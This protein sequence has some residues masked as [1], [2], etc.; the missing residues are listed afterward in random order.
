MIEVND[1]SFTYAGSTKP[2]LKHIDLQIARGEIIGFLGPSGAGKS[3]AQK[4]LIG[5]LK[6]YQGTVTVF[7]R[8]LK[9]WR[10]DYYERIGVAFEQ[11]NHYLKLSALEN[12]AYFRSLYAGETEEPQ[13]L[14]ELVGLA[15]DGKK[16]VSQFSKGMGMRLNVAR[17][18]LNKPEL[19]FL[20]EPTSGLD[21]VNARQIKDLLQRKRQEGMTIFLTTHNM[22][23][24]DEL[25]DRVAFLIDGVIK[26]VDAP[27]KLKI[28]R[29]KRLVEVEYGLYDHPQRQLF[30]LDGLAENSAFLALL[31]AAEYLLAKM[32]SLMLLALLEGTLL[33]ILI[34]GFNFNPLPWFAGLLL[35]SGFY[36]LLGFA[37]IA[38]YRSLN[39][40]LLP[41]ALVVA[42]LVSP[43]LNHF[44]LWRSFIFYLH[45]VQP[46]LILLRWAF[47][48]VA[49]WEI[50]Y[51]L[52]G[53]LFW[54]AVAFAIAHRVFNRAI[55]QTAGG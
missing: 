9:A 16:P 28:E 6:S 10:S 53:S 7:G 44:G 29:G 34:N 50:V 20:D 35:L 4:I 41:S 3:T 54:L 43:I 25:C 27:E 48:P 17:A 37:V 49:P 40:S 11:P 26:L 8:D 47:M 30:P 1:L 12:L 14:L 15:D 13:A 23:V 22:T 31:R 38:R 21:P 33:A 19:L 18:L 55:V 52:L 46:A 51:G 24:A 2:A 42:V 45:P 36:T 39:E 32:L 5:L